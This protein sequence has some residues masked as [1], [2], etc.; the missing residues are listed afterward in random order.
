M[1]IFF[2]LHVMQQGIGRNCPERIPESS[3]AEN[4]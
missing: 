4:I 1:A 2:L 3:K